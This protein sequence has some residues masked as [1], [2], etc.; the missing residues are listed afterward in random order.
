MYQTTDWKGQPV[1]E[2][3]NG[4]RVDPDLYVDVS[5]AKPLARLKRD[6]VY[7][8]CSESRRAH[9]IANK[10]RWHIG[11]PYQTKKYSS[12][13]HIAAY[14]KALGT[15]VNDAETRIHFQQR[16]LEAA[17]LVIEVTQ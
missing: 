7:G 16:I 17:P 8:M 3:Q 5:D 1:W 15:S 10:H 4:D 12:E 11:P 13:A 6:K 14:A 2:L 9:T